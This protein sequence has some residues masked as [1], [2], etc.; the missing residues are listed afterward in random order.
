MFYWSILEALLIFDKEREKLR[1]MID[2]KALNL[3]SK[4]NNGLILRAG[5]MFDCVG[6][7]SYYSTLNLS[8]DSYQNR[9]APENIEKTAFKTNHGNF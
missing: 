4:H 1:S 6:K 7:A 3:I 9:A 2:Y 8:S 5:K